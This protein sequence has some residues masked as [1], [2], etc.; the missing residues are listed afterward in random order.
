[1]VALCFRPERLLPTEAG[2]LPERYVKTKSAKPDAK[3]QAYEQTS[4]A[5]DLAAS[6]AADLA[7]SSVADLAANVT[8]NGGLSVV[9][10]S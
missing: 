9:V 7:A 6:S 1:M 5:T 8:L 4:S 2:R 10:V 3:K